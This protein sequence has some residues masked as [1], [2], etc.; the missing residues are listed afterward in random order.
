[1]SISDFSQ[2]TYTVIVQPLL[3]YL[4]SLAHYGTNKLPETATPWKPLRQSQQGGSFR[5]TP[6]QVQ[7]GLKC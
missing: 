4:C 3:E 2:R 1:M 5:T 6:V 7:A